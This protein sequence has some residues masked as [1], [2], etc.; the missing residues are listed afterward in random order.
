MSQ[1][2]NQFELVSYL[3][4]NESLYLLKEDKAI[5]TTIEKKVESIPENKIPLHGNLTDSNALI[6]TDFDNNNSFES[7]SCHELLTKILKAIGYDIS[8]VAFFHR[9]ESFETPLKDVLAFY[10]FD[11]VICFAEFE[12][13]KASYKPLKVKGITLIAAHPLSQLEKND[14]L[15][16]K[17]WNVLKEVF[18]L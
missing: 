1:N 11:T 2:D 17:L 3:F 16:R 13:L 14:D 7:S 9:N 18:K 5:S 12:K 8:K 15:K 4:E 6:V 10:P